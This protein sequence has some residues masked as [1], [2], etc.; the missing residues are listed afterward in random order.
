[1]GLIFTI[2]GADYS[3]PEPT[4]IV[5]NFKTRYEAAGGTLSTTH[6]NALKKL[7]EDLGVSS[8]A[9]EVLHPFLGTTAA[10]QA[11]G[12]FSSTPLTF[13]GT[14]THSNAGYGNSTTAYANSMT[15]VETP[16]FTI[17]CFASPITSPTVTSAFCGA[18]SPYGQVSLR[19][20]GNTSQGAS[21]GLLFQAGSIAVIAAGTRLTVTPKYMIGGDNN[22]QIYMVSDQDSAGVTNSHAA[23]TITGAVSQIFIGGNNGGTGNIANT[24]VTTYKAWFKASYLSL[25]EA[26]TVAT[27]INT[28][29]NTIGRA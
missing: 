13:F 16:N 21:N 8:S 26:K 9:F 23:A 3:I 7:I 12:L 27:A 22:S 11:I 17:G 5:D 10:T 4:D 24:Y 20:S 6:Y 18:V 29:L 1:M 28:F 14:G 19:A 15:K 25:S 2:K